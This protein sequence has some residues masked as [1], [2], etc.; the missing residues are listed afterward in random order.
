MLQD[1]Q[2]ASDARSAGDAQDIATLRRA[3]GRRTERAEQAEAC[4][5]HIAAEQPVRPATPRLLLDDKPQPL[6]AGAVIYHG[7]GATAAHPWHLED[8]EL[9][10]VKGDRL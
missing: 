5:G 4:A 6:A 7:I 10:G 2:H 9:T 8:H 3:E 1:G